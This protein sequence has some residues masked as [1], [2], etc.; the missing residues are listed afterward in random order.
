MTRD[1]FW[2]YLETVQRGESLSA[3]QSAAAFSLIMAGEVA[4][5]DLADFLL[6]QSR[7]GPAA[8]EIVGAARAMRA[9]MLSIDAPAN[10]IDLCGTG[11]DSLGTLN[12]STAVSFVV[13][14][15]GA[16]VAKHGNRNMSSRTG[17]A[18]VLE[19]L[20]VN[21][22]LSPGAA[23]ACL[24]EAGICFLFAPLYHPAMKHVAPVRKQL[25]VR[26]IFN[27]LGPLCNPANVKRQLL[28]VYARDWIAPLAQVLRDLG[29]ERAWVVHGSDGMDEMTIIG[30]TD[31]AVLDRGTIAAHTVV[32]EEAGIARGTLA[33]LQGGDAAYNADAVRRLFDGEGAAAYRDIVLLNAAAAL[34]IAEKAQD[35]RD[36][37][38]RAAAALDDGRARAVLEK[39]AALSHEAK[40]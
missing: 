32:P 24:R 36:A 15:C 14:A 4:E 3:E 12:I 1:R 29:A 16:P 38:D 17:A 28:G 7:R 13:A 26:T 11:G 6:A 39:L 35:L 31:I 18:D 20:G 22:S 40:A 2:P 19:A 8:P 37:R 34:V 27:L 33:E 21:V 25:G 9:S 23:A 30:T 5:G 10:T